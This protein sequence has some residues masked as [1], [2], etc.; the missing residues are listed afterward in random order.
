MAYRSLTLFSLLLSSALAQDSDLV[1]CKAVSC[2]IEGTEDRCTVAEDI[3]LGIGAAPIPDVPSS[4]EGL[5]LVKGV[6]LTVGGGEASENTRE[7][8]SVYYLG[9]PSNLEVNDLAG[10]AVFFNDPP[11]KTFRYPTELAG[12]RDDNEEAQNVTDTAAAS[13]TCS[14]V[15]NQACIDRLT[16]RARSIINDADDNGCALLEDEL[17]SSS[18]DECS[19]SWLGS[20]TLGNLTITPLENLQVISG[21]QNSS[22][23]CWPVV[24]KAD[25][26]SEIAENTSYVRCL[27]LL[28]RNALTNLLNQQGN[29]TADAYTQ[30][31]YKITPVLTVFSG[32]GDNNLVDETTSQMTCL[33]VVKDRPAEDY[34]GGDKGAAFQVRP[35]LLGAG[36]VTLMAVVLTGL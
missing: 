36:M 8:K 5:S 2:P 31:V 10:C 32:N 7:F 9:T 4:L 28:P 30:Q 27:F 16:E 12:P 18:F 17:N 22:S 3:F 20:S 35:S 23:D 1:G 15:I 25:N 6:N 11:A 14:E 34:E 29:D 19:D 24:S 33:K 21:S 26:L 13:G